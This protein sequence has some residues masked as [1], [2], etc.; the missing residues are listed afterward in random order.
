MMARF[1]AR[2][3]KRDDVPTVSMKDV[4]AGLTIAGL[5]SLVAPAQSA[6]EAQPTGTRA[7]VERIY[8]EVLAEIL[9]ADSVAT[10]KHFFDE[11]GADSM[12]MARFCARMRKR[13]DVP[14]VSMKDVYAGPSI[15][16]LVALVSGDIP[17]PAAAQ[18]SPPTE[19]VKPATNGEVALCGALQLG[20]GLTYAFLIALWMTA[21]LHWII[22]GESFIDI[23]TRAMLF[24]CGGFVLL[25]LAPIL[26]KWAVIGRWT[27]RQIR[28]WSLDYLRFWTVKFLIRSNPL[29]L[30]RGTPIYNAYLRALGAKIGRNVV[31]DSPHVPVCTDLLTI[32]DNAVIRKDTYYNCYRAHA[33]VIQTGPVSIGK[34]TLVGEMT[35]LDIDTSLGDRAQI[36]HS[37]AL[38]AGQS[39]PAGEHRCGSP[40]EHLTT[41]D[42][43]DVPAAE[44]GTLR[45]VVYC[46]IAVLPAL[47]ITPAFYYVLTVIG[48]LFGGRPHFA[49]PG[50]A[51]FLHWEMYVDA[52]LFSA[53][54]FVGAILV[55]LLIVGTVP[56]LLNRALEPGKVYPLYGVHYAIHRAIGRMTNVRFFT[57]LFGDSSF[58]VSYVKWI[59]YDMPN[60]VQTGSNFGTN[61]KHDNPF[62]VTVGSGTVVADGLSVINTD[63]S[64]TSFRLSRATIGSNNFLGNFV[65]YPA[66]GKTGDDCLLAT[67]VMVPLDGKVREGVGLLGSPS[68]EIPRTVARDRDLELNDDAEQAR[69]LATKDKHNLRTMGLFLAVYWFDAFLMTLVVFSVA[70]F[71]AQLDI[72]PA[73]LV[74]AVT[75]LLAVFMRIG[76]HILVERLSTGFQS[77]RPRQC[78]IYDPYFW[79]HERY[80]KMS[81]SLQL[82]VLDGTPLKGV[83]LRLHGMRIGARLFDDGC[84]MTER[85]MIAIGDDCTL[86]AG[87]I[88][89][90]HSQEDGA[91]KSDRIELGAGCTLGIGAW[92]HYGSKMGDGSALAPNAFLMKGEEVPAGALWAE[93]PAR[94]I[95][96]GGS[97][98][99]IAAPL[100][101]LAIPA[102]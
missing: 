50:A 44:C 99:D 19:P 66:K 49:S 79:Y 23:Y 90:P 81:A 37:S 13:D 72:V 24:T 56:R 12:V 73:A 76:Y 74:A 1:C 28:I 33:G 30:F 22:A 55:G 82:A 35:V 58:V 83:A 36:G 84:G 88:I 45:K 59:G 31:I 93:N 6:S 100:E 52:I 10:D 101:A 94:E 46:L 34:D 57:Y 68:F 69:R 16:R 71:Y 41:V 47:L 51:A 96:G 77:L 18:A 4:Y 91:F 95:S 20:V 26:A 5:V 61:L 70:E 98:G 62:L 102:Q 54:S 17:A 3:R 64:N 42:Y 89:Q 40:A 25:S 8:A 53:L 60:V 48:D 67:K 80:W 65:T 75:V 7:D 43:R 85:T 27:P 2:I 9:G 29:V 97:L 15:E 32:G 78:S 11:L 63:Y 38:Y 86:N 21:G 39:I 14:T 87:S 92:A